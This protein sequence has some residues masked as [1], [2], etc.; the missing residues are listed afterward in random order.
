[1]LIIIRKK[2]I[3]VRN[4]VAKVMFLQA[5]VCPRGGGGGGSAW[6]GTPPRQV[7]PSSPRTRYT[8]WAVTPP[9]PGLPTPQPGPG[10]PPGLVP[11]GPGTP[12][13]EIRP[14]LRT[15]R[16]LLECILVSFYT[17]IW[18]ICFLAELLLCK[19]CPHSHTKS[20]VHFYYFLSIYPLLEISPDFGWNTPPPPPI[21]ADWNKFSKFSLIGGNPVMAWKS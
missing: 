3:T 10:T 21:F 7:H 6:P 4:E 5:C 14:L 17:S 20:H 9:G 13:P 2:L 12:P 11:P 8:P 19:T 16:I 1:M 18:N 15:V